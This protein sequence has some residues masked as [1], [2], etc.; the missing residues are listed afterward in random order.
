MRLRPFVLT[1]ALL[2]AVGSDP[3]V[4]LRVDSARSNQTWEGWEATVEQFHIDVPSLGDQHRV[5]QN[6]LN[7]LIDDAVN[8]LGLTALRL[9][10]HP[11]HRGG[12]MEEANDNKDPFV[13]DSGKI[14]W[15]NLDA[16]VRCIA[17]PFK[18]RVEARGEKFSLNLHA[19][20]WAS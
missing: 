5:P 10:V 18:Q 16:Y 13:L 17:I 14:R 20:A 7:G 4:T 11:V 15:A 1:A 6:I 8:N 2:T 9:E 3:A 12:G 19:V